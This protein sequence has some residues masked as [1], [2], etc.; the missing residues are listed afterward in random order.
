MMK[1]H[2]I[3]KQWQIAQSRVTTID[4]HTGIMCAYKYTCY[5]LLDKNNYKGSYHMSDEII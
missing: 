3:Y 4:E 2:Y 1:F 5:M